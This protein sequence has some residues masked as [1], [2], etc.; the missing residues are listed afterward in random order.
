MSGLTDMEYL[1]HIVPRYVPFVV[2]STPPS[3]LLSC[4]SLVTGF[5]TRIIRH[6]PLLKRKLLTVSE[7]L[8]SPRFCSQSLAFC[9]VL[10]ESMFVFMFIF[11][12]LVL[13]VL[14][15]F[16]AFAYTFGIFKLFLS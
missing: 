2:I 11:L 12:D 7:N 14:S 5:L 13:C 1:D 8:S 16:T 10:C 4:L 3:F 6:M 9:V 15:R